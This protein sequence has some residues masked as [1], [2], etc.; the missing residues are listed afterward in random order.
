MKILFATYPWAFE[1]PGGGEIQLRKYAEHLPAHGVE[2]MLHDPW[3]ANLAE[4]QAVHFFSCIGGS[5]HFCD[6]VKRRG[7]PLVISSSLWIT[8]D[9]RHLYPA[10][11][12]R[13][14]LSLAD[15]IVTNSPTESEQLARVLAL[16]LE[17]FAAVM[18]GFEPRFAQADARLFRDAFGIDGRFALNVGTIEPRKNQLGLVRALKDAG[19]PVVLIGHR[20]DE[21]YADQVLAEGGTQVHYLGHLD[22]DDP[23]LASAFAACAVFALPSTL[24]T[25]GLAALEAA[26]AGAAVVVTSEGSARD[27]FGDHAGYANH[28][29]P[30]DIRRAVEQA[31]Q[32]GPN[33]ALKVHV[34]NH[35]AW[36]V[37]TAA[38]P[39]IY[40][41]ALRNNRR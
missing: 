21:A 26:A 1:T 17:R 41:Q 7:L 19:L 32:R 25:P 11:E 30:V 4:A 29:D 5:V 9:T 39:G 20:R 27:Y 14:Q 16:P 40:R 3:R 13:A 8:E 33:P 18:N 38:L 36:N 22:H 10:D 15:V 31:L 37:V 28:A 6:Y 35:F 23:R 34:L 2:V 24:E 12:I